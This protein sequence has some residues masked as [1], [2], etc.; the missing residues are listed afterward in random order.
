M[1][2][3][4][5]DN[6]IFAEGENKEIYEVFYGKIKGENPQACVFGAEFILSSHKRN[7][8]LMAGLGLPKRT[9]DTFAAD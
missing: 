6:E 4:T 9:T 3:K 7:H 1:A 2:R 5:R 8:Y